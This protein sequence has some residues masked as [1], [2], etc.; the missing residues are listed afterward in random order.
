MIGIIL[1]GLFGWFGRWRLL[2]I[3]FLIDFAIAVANGG[4]AL[5]LDMPSILTG[6]LLELLAIALGYGIGA[7][8]HRIAK[9]K[10]PSHVSD[11]SVGLSS[12]GRGYVLAGIVL[13]VLVFVWMAVIVN[14]G[15]SDAWWWFEWQEFKFVMLPFFIAAGL[16]IG[17][18]VRLSRTDREK[19]ER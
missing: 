6:F 2:W 14:V 11:G 12:A 9:G 7:L 15:W 17:W 16:S 1:G 13:L 3:P 19:G 18:G 5:P 4:G 8:I 10:W